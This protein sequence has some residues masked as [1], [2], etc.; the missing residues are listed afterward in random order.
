M[1]TNIH[2]ALKR[3][4]LLAAL[5]AMSMGAWAEGEVAQIG[6]TKYATLQAAVN[7]AADGATI[8]LLSSISETVANTTNANSF[9]IDL[10][11]FTWSYSKTSDDYAALKQ[12][13]E[14]SVITL[15]NGTITTTTNEGFNVWART[16]K[17]IIESGSYNVHTHEDYNVYATGGYVDIKGGIFT[18]NDNNAYEHNA[19]LHNL[20][21][22]VHN[23]VS[24]VE[25]LKVYGGSFTADPSKGDDAQ[26]GT[27]TFVAEGYV[28]KTN[29]GTP[30]TYTVEPKVKTEVNS[31]ITDETQKTAALALAN[32]TS[33]GAVTGL[34]TN[35]SLEVTIKGVTLDNT[36]NTKVTSA[37][38]EVTLK[39]ASGTSQS[40]SSSAITFRL[41]VSSGIEANKWANLKHDTTVLPGTTVKE[42][43]GNKYV[44][45]TTTTFSPFSYEILSNDPVVVIGETKFDNIA[46]AITA[47][48]TTET[49]ITFLAD[50]LED[51]TIPSYANITLVVGDYTYS[52]TITNNDNGTCVLSG[53]TY[54]NL[55]PANCCTGYMPV[56]NSDGKYNLAN[57]WTI[58]D[59]TSISDYSYL[60]DKGYS[61]AT[62][63]YDRTTGMAAVGTNAATKYG[64]ICLPFDINAAVSGVN[65]YTATS[66][67]ESTLTI[68]EAS[69]PVAAG[70]SL[71][72]ELTSA[73]TTMSITS[74]NATVN[75]ATPAEAP[76][77]DN[78]LVGTLEGKTLN[79]GL[80]KIY[81]LN[82][83][84]FHQAKSSLT[85]PS[86]RAYLDITSSSSAPQMI[87]IV[88]D[89][90]DATGISEVMNVSSVTEVYDM[91]GRKQN[92]LQHG[93]NIVRRADGSTIKVI[94][95]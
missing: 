41:P 19:S 80:D 13:K 23:S 18:N 46:T 15:K 86:Y 81:Y 33:T 8:T 69:Y 94:V 29:S 59:D 71:I 62:A 95:K 70:T 5:I 12:D 61:V 60:A 83:D 92:G 32:N 43:S 56:K 44:E 66:I 73:A 35:E 87:S 67:S 26:W 36:D 47:A 63:K 40:T 17:V 11:S 52:G 76:V 28:V 64:T 14:G 75:T 65:L 77:T 20:N 57:S 88:K 6:E 9:T 1:K 37:T 55:P 3:T 49:T 72:F 22:N 53:G 42:E 79:S 10:G 31:G 68:T 82:G 24:S 2:T 48:G 78:I 74:N 93:V 7:A 34:G 85:V 21:L 54:T 90:E 58:G 91:N 45:I 16:G 27:S 38:F 84:K 51:I 4:F 39:N 89:G 25:H 50:A 30:T